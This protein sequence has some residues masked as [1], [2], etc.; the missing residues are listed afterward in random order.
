[1]SEDYEYLTRSS[2]AMVYLTMRRLMLARLAKQ[3]KK[4]FVTYKEKQVA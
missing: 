4:Q 3:T 1:M 2:E